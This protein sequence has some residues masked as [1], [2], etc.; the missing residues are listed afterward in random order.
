[1]YLLNSTAKWSCKC[2]RLSLAENSELSEKQKLKAIAK[3]VRNTKDVKTSK[4][5][6]TTKKTKQGSMATASGDKVNSKLILCSYSFFIAFLIF[7]V[8][9]NLWIKD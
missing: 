2:N 5:Y 9:S 4:I 7:R 3:A 8:N 1:M 6:V